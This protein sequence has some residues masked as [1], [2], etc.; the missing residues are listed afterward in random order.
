MQG[1]RRTEVKKINNPDV[2]KKKILKEGTDA[3]KTRN[4]DKENPA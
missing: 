4:F 1:N 3:L 2:I